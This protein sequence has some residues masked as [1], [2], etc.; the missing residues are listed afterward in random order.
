[1]IYR[2]SRRDFLKYAGLTAAQVAGYSSLTSRRIHAQGPTLPFPSSPQSNPVLADA[3]I[4]FESGSASGT[5][6]TI[7]LAA[8]GT[9]GGNGYWSDGPFTNLTLQSAGQLSNL[10][11]PVK[12]GSTLYTGSGSLGS[13]YTTSSAL[14][15][16]IYI[17][18]PSSNSVSVGFWFMTDM[19]TSDSS[20]CDMFEVQNVGGTQHYA[21]LVIDDTGQMKLET[22]FGTSSSYAYSANTLYWVTIQ[23]NTSAAST[24]N[25][26]MKIFSSTGVLLATLTGG[27]VTSPTQANV[28]AIGSGGDGGQTVG[29]HWWVDNVEINYTSGTFPLGP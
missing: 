27:T 7:A 29:L 15:Q 18:T 25:D 3:L 9:I 1:M 14:N 16:M 22:N 17:F 21:V 8:S 19:P 11:T 12:I 2:P 5:E 4:N 20:T 6:L 10:L 28:V 23:Y 24:T 13:Q 26:I